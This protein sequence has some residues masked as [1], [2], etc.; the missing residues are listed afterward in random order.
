MIATNKHQQLILLEPGRAEMLQKL[1]DRTGITKQALLREAVDLL[2]AK[3]GPAH[4]SLEFDTWR[5][6]LQMCYVR[7]AG[8][9]QI[10]LPQAADG[11]CTDVMARI[12]QILVRWGVSK[13]TLRSYD[14]NPPIGAN[15]H[16]AK[17]GR[18]TATK[19]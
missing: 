3:S 11:A 15:S 10:E 7:L 17:R 1:A 19:K 13:Q 9:R 5:E 2:L 4:V 12:W 14:P 16:K 18:K 8:A 6:S